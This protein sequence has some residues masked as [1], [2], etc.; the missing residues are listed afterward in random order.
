[1]KKIL[2]L[3]GVAAL[4]PFLANS[5]TLSPTVV[6]SSGG[7]FSNTSGSLSFTVAE[8]TMVQTF[9]TTGNIL[10]QGFQQPEQNTVGITEPMIA[11]GDIVAYPNPTTGAFSLQFIANENAEK[12]ISIYNSM[13][14]VVF[15]KTYQ[16]VS[17]LNKV[18]FDISQF[19]QGMYMVELN[20]KNSNGASKP[21][22]RKINL[23]Y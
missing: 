23:I 21:V 12:V 11:E 17:G 8:M 2:T 5:Q 19:S 22:F 7:Y 9:T 16:Q 15:Q 20:L 18:N 4:V 6:A 10:T 14:Q 13:G 3:L 1:M